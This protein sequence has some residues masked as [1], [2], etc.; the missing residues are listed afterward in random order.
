M[1]NGDLAL[2]QR[3]R[4]SFCDFLQINDDFAMKNATDIIFKA[5]KV[6]TY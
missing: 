4:V 2:K 3:E 1:E 5:E 6:L